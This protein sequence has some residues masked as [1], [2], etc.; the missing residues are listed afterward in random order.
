[1]KDQQ[2]EGV[3]GSRGM[4]SGRERCAGRSLEGEMSGTR[5]GVPAERRK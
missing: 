5:G 4:D 1:M 3:S 2:T